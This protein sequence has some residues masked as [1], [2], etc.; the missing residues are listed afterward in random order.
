MQIQ[1]LWGKAQAAANSSRILMNF[2]PGFY[3]S[4]VVF[5]WRNYESD[6]SNKSRNDE[7]F[8]E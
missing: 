8:C 5:M 4:F 3:E 1:N 6:E 7:S 2:F